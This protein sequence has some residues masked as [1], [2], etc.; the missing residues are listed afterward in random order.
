MTD[1]TVVSW[2]VDGWHTL[3]DEQLTLLDGTN[4]SVAMLQD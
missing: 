4:A 3:R 1:L 2:N